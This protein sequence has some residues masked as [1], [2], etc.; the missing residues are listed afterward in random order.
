MVTSLGICG[1]CGLP[2][3]RVPFL[4]GDGKAHPFQDCRG[5]YAPT[6]RKSQPE[7]IKR[8]ERAEIGEVSVNKRT[9]GRPRLWADEAERM[10]AYRARGKG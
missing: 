9:R 3:G 5:E 6:V 8:T 2:K 7:P 4:R 1:D 10:R